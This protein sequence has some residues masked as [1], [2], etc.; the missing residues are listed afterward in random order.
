MRSLAR[1]SL[2][3]HPGAVEHYRF[4]HAYDQ[5][6][7]GRSEDIGFYARLAK[8]KGDVIEYGAG[9]GR[10]TLPLAR[11]GSRVLAV[12]LAPAMLAVLD[13]HLQAEPAEVRRRVA[14]AEGDMRT[15]ATRRRFGLAIV[16]FHTFCHLYTRAD[17]V[18]FLARVHAHLEPG[19]LLAFD[20]PVPRTD[21]AGYD[22]MSQ[23]CLTEMDGPDGPE[24]L[25]QRWYQPQELVAHLLYNGFEKPKFHGDFL[26]AAPG[27]DTDFLAV[28]SRRAP[29]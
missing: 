6:Y 3:V 16:G 24:L 22:A 1:Q 10:L 13:E 14:I 11:A 28:V 2:R 19:G 29:C 20:V 8:G 5:R 26:Q 27:P 21:A 9:T 23:V 4:G 18:A 7:H 25:T 12:D 17:V 15:F